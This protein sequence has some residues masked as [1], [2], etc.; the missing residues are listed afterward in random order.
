MNDSGFSM[1]SQ[2]DRPYRILVVDDNEL[3]L[4]MH[5]ETLQSLSCQ[6]MTTDSGYKALTL[7]EQEDFDLVLLDKRLP[8]IDGDEVCYRIR[9]DLDNHLLPV[10]MVTAFGNPESLR[11]SLSNGANDF[12]KK[13]YDPLELKSRARAAMEMKH[14][15]DQLDNAASVLFTLA[16]MVEARDPTTGEHCNRLI[17]T[18]RIL[19]EDLN[20]TVTD[21]EA[22]RKG[23]ILHDIGKIGIP[24]SVLL[25]PGELTPEE[26]RVMRR[27][28]VIGADLCNRLNSVRDAVPIIR[29]HHERWD[30]SGY[31]DGLSGDRIPLVARV[32]QY[33]DI[34]DA[35]RHDR[36]YS[37]A[38]TVEYVIEVIE[39]EIN[40]GWRDPEIGKVFIDLL[41]RDPGRFDAD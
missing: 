29:H 19:G 17:R 40:K 24:D 14:L 21:R 6:V 20:L 15:I 9:R 39:D 1:I 16:K 38:Q 22:L 3:H 25:K 34:Y 35:L 13:P 32:F 12:I 36:V 7:V 23:A 18:C 4:T 10:I 30:G 28:A 31:P 8:D 41:M 11:H 27:H 37:K 5:V 2:P 33:A 26:W